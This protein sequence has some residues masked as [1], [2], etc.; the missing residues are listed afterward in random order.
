MTT[1]EINLHAPINQLGFGIFS[2]IYYA[3]LIDHGYKINWEPI[4]TPDDHVLELISN[5]YALDINELRKSL[6]SP[7]NPNVPTLTIWHPMDLSRRK[8]GSM[9]IGLTH[10]ETTLLQGE[11]IASMSGCDVVA[12]C[13]K[14]GQEVLRNHAIKAW[15]VV[16]PGVCAPL[17]LSD[18]SYSPWIDR[19]EAYLKNDSST[20][21]S[22]VGKWELRKD[23]EVLLKSMDS[24]PPNKPVSIIGCWY[25]SFTDGLNSPIKTLSHMNYVYKA[26]LECDN[27]HIQ[28][29]AKGNVNCYLLPFLESQK[30]LMQ[31]MKIS[32]MFISTSRGEGWDQPLVEA[33]SLGPLCIATHNTAHAH[34]CNSNNSVPISTKSEIA[35]DGI[36]FN[37]DKGFWFPA[38]EASVISSINTAYEIQN[39]P[40]LKSKLAKNAYADIEKICSKENIVNSLEEIIEEYE[41]S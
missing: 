7:L 33:M 11:E 15:K 3:A 6:S 28:H 17:L 35:D 36:W 8:T 39:N 34:Y 26:T 4:G 18:T 16:L 31:L 13:S 5:D 21:I 12:V 32:D 23:Q 27:I 20:I 41:Q 30:D 9:L 38:E 14:W 40:N 19:F 25:N 2:T 10:F 1:K 22:S 37:R 24:H 29:Y